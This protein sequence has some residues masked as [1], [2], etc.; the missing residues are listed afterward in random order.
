[1]SCTAAVESGPAGNSIVA[2]SGVRTRIES[3]NG[4]PMRTVSV[5]VLTP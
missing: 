4:S 3:V 2:P 5:D 1:M